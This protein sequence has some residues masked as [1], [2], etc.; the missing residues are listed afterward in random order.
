MNAAPLERLLDRIHQG[1][2]AAVEHLVSAYEPYLRVMIRR[3][4][5]D[6]IRAR[7]DS[8]DVVQSVWVHV[9]TGL[10]AGNWRFADERRLRSFLLEVARRRLATRMRRHFSTAQREK[11]GEDLDALPGM[12]QP[13]PSEV[14]Q[15]EELWQQMLAFCP[16]DHHEILRLR[17][18][19][20][21]L[22][23]IAQRR[24]MH[25]GS[26]R[27]ILRR[28]ARQMT[29]QQEPLAPCCTPE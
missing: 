21:T 9:L 19:G 3:S 8:V 5:P 16:P 23:E 1:D 17:R 20:L 2:E 4:L 27:R 11:A 6:R 14:A 26:V 12:V 7:F 24:G 29:L 28:L 25:E 10:R 18:Q 22:D 15:A 13:R